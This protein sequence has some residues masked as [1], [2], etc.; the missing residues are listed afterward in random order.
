MN[1]R[2]LFLASRSLRTLAVVVSVVGLTWLAPASA[3][4]RTTTRPAA[5]APAG[6]HGHGHQCTK[7]KA[8]GVGQD[9]GEGMTTATISVHGVAVGTTGAT[10]TITGVVDRRRLVHRPDRL[11][12]RP[13]H[14]DRRGDGDTRH[15]DRAVHLEVDQGQRYRR[16][17][18]SDRQA[19][20]PRHRGPRQPGPSPRRSPA[21]CVRPRADLAAG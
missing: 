7:I 15:H 14:A 8:I 10:S 9:L 11:H 5:F 12:L 16:L 20:L 13:G 2:N 19:D 17:R 3:Q 6:Q 4:A 18:R 1:W 21:G